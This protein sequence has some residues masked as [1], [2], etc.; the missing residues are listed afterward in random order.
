[1]YELGVSTET[2]IT[3][4][5]PNESNEALTFWAALYQKLIAPRLCLNLE[6]GISF[7]N[8]GAGNGH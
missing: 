7:G 1:M 6:G 3:T 8:E 5:C 4:P 2:S